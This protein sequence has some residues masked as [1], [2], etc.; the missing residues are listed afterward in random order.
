MCGIIGRVGTEDG[1]QELLDG[2]SALEYRG[3][4]S[5]GIAMKNGNGLAVRKN[6]GEVDT[7]INN[8][9]LNRPS[10]TVGIGHTRWST[11][12]AP[13]DD[14]AHPHTDCTGDVAVVHN[15]IIDNHDAL[16]SRLE[17]EGHKFHSDTDTE[18]VPHLIE[19]NLEAGMD[20][21]EAFRAAVK[22]L[23][24]SYAVVAVF[25]GD[26]TLY[27]AREGSPLVLG[28]DRERFF[29]AS[30]VTAFIAHT[31]EVI[32]LEDGDVIVVDVDGFDISDLDGNRV[33]RPPER[34]NW[35]VE[36]AGKGGYEHFMLKEIHEQPDSLRQAIRSRIDADAGKAI[37]EE[38][39]EGTFADVDQVQ[40]VACG[41]SYHAA[42][43]C[44][45]F[46][47]DMGIQA[48]AYLGGEYASYPSPVD[49]N[50]LV[51]AVSQ[52]GET[53]DTLGAIRAIK[54]TPARTMVVT[55]T[56]GST[57][58]R[59][60][61]DA[62]FIRAGPEIGVA[63]T[64]TFSSQVVTLSLLA[65]RILSDVNGG[66]TEGASERLEALARLPDDVESILGEGLG[67]RVARQFHRSD[68]YFFIGRGLGFPVA[69]E[70]A[71][72]FKEISYEHAEGFAASELKHGP[73][74]LITDKTPV[75]A[76][77]TGRDDEKTLSNVKEVQ[78][79]GAPIIS[80]TSELDGEIERYSDAVLP[81][82]ETHPVI[83]GALANIQLQLVA[84]YA[85]NQLDRAIDKPRNLAKCV[86]VE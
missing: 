74:A 27:A 39:D 26:E 15:G 77:F 85:A 62:L 22:E 17:S 54:D 79:R 1:V 67:E 52:S 19:S 60:C 73:L 24:G 9:E 20:H 5:A 50:T 2:L 80:V 57:L 76:I 3:Y 30:D 33:E 21:A 11:H 82:P 83:S 69:L 31:D 23:S 41:T 4:D 16:K 86:T 14:N 7:L 61:D 68:S 59:E 72:K 66:P 71:L 48:N 34:I 10:G 43:Y 40:F 55:N 6:A 81:I 47:Q 84:Y 56:V 44:S 58:T 32:Y 45:R 51:V 25:D 35:N 64:K 78:S 12:G 46:L 28:L 37:L 70:S 8:V 63:A 42:M 65:E 18:V 53:A 49:E 38:F 75:F 36:D 29:L 13:S